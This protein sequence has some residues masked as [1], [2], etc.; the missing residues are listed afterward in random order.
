MNHVFYTTCQRVS[1][2]AQFYCLFLFS[3]LNS[4]EHCG[5]LK[6][7]ISICTLFVDITQGSLSELEVS[8]TLSVLIYLMEEKIVSSSW[9]KTKALPFTLGYQ[10]YRFL[11]LVTLSW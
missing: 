2:F 1:L 4:T 7:S 8:A 3:Y 6:A 5:H 9:S 11:L 10:S